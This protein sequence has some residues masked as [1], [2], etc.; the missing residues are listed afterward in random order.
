MEIAATSRSPELPRDVLMHIFALLEVPDLVRAGS[1]CSSWNAAFAGVRSTGQYKQ[2]QTPCLLYTSGPAGESVACLYSLAEKR[3]Y[4]LTLP[5][6][7]IHRRHLIGSS[8][9]W[10]VTVDER[11]EM[12]LVNPITSE[13]IA[14]PSVITMDH[15]APIYD[16]AGAICEYCYWNNSTDLVNKQSITLA[17]GELRYYL[18]HKALLLHDTSTGS[19]IVVFI[20]N[21]W[22][23]LAF[24]RLGDKK[25]T[26]LTS[27]EHILDCVYKGGLLYAVTAFGEI[28]AFDINGTVITTRIIMDR[29]QN[30]FGTERVYIVGRPAASLEFTDFDEGRNG[31][32]SGWA[33]ISEQSWDVENI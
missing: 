28:I 3:A 19:Y 9:G 25:W 14:L 18:H 2:P 5:E 21:P 32:A 23:Q 31:W 8:H 13:Q 29:V 27:H 30:H 15:V 24:A 4:R 1:V 6:P 11:S 22:R 7:P 16:S 33:N 10:M 12:H 20:H 26:Q 17:P